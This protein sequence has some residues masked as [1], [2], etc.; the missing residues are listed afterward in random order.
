METINRLH[1]TF[2]TVC[3]GKVC[4]LDCQDTLASLFLSRVGVS[5]FV[6]VHAADIFWRAMMMWRQDGN[7][8]TREGSTMFCL[9]ARRSYGM[10]CPK[11]STLNRLVLAKSFWQRWSSSCSGK[12][13]RS[14]TV[15]PWRARNEGT[16]FSEGRE[17][18]L[19]SGLMI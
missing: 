18:E 14:S 17:G 7:I 10:S 12:R 4:R 8:E 13:L 5:F 11:K 9:S 15:S 2:K 16:A 6:A 1:P 19:K 3:L